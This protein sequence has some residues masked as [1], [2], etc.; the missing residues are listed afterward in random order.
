MITLNL[1]DRVQAKSF[2]EQGYSRVRESGDKINI[3][4]CFYYFGYLALFEGDIEQANGFFEQELVLARTTGPIW[5]GSQAL[6]GLAGVGAARGQA[7]RAA[8]LLGAAEARLKAGASYIDAADGLFNER[9]VASVVA[10][11]GEITFAEAC[12]EGRAMT[13]EQ[14]A[15]YAFEVN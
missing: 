12:A 5:L 13:F 1:G 9:T 10:Q 7:W 3:A 8:R 11:L 2:F 15:D 4:I 14:A 6:F